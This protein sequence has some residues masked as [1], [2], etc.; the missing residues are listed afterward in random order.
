MGLF[1]TTKKKEIPSTENPIVALSNAQ[2]ALPVAAALVGKL[3][4][5]LNNLRNQ[6]AT[7]GGEPSTNEIAGHNVAIKKCARE[8]DAKRKQKSVLMSRLEQQQDRLI[9]AAIQ[10]F[11]QAVRRKNLYLAGFEQ[12]KSYSKELPGKIAEIEKKLSKAKEQEALLRSQIA[13]AEKEVMS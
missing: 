13:E 11:D 3:D 5:R 8:V 1:N 9:E 10:R 12:R 6:L 7:C 2:A 4:T